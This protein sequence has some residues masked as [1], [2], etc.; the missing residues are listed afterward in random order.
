VSFTSDQSSL[1]AQ[2]PAFVLIIIGRRRQR[3][4]EL[5]EGERFDLVFSVLDLVGEI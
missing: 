4:E 2:L 5:G 1:A 3:R